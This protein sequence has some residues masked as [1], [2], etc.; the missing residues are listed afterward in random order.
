ML[1]TAATICSASGDP[2]YNTFD[3]AVHHYMGNCSYTLTKLCDVSSIEFPYFHVYTTNEHRGG[4]TKVSYIQ[5]VHV[6]V[7]NTNF[8]LLKNKKLNVD[9][10]R[11]NLPTALESRIRVHISGNY[12][13]LETNFGLQVR[14]DGNHYSDVSL[15]STFKGHVCGLCGNYNDNA[16]DDSLKPDGSIAS[17]SKE[18]GDSWLVDRDNKVCGSQDIENCDPNLEAEYSKDTVCGIITDTAGIFKDC[19]ALVNPDNFFENC[20]IDM[21][22]TGGDSNSLCYAVQAYAQQCS[23]AGICVEW[24]SDT[25]CP[26]SCP[27]RSYYKSC[28]TTCPA[29]CFNSPPVAPCKLESVEGCFCND[30]YVLSGDR[31]VNQTDC[32]CVDD[33]NNSY[34][35]G[36]SWFTYE[37]C[38]QRCSC[39]DNNSIVCENWQCGTLENCKRQDGVLGCHSSGITAC[40]VSGDPHFYTFDKVM[41]SFMGTCTYVLVD[42]CDKRS[43]IPFT[44]KGKTEDRG[45]RTATYLKEVYIDVYDFRIT[46][47]KD[48]KTLVDNTR[49]QTPWS[50]NVKGISIG[51]VGL[52]TVVTTDFG[53]IVKFDGNHHL[54]IVLPDAYFGKVCG[55]CGNFNTQTNDELLMSNG[56]LAANVTQFGNSWK[57]EEDSDKNCMDD[58]RVDLVPP[59]T[60]ATRPNIQNQC[61]VLLTDTFK[62]C[63]NLVSAD[64]FIESC[65]YDMCRYNGMVSTLCAIVQAY[66]DACRTQG[67]NIKWRSPSLCP[68]ACPKNSHYT[69]CASL[70]PSTCTNIYAP[71]VCDKPTTCMEGC[72]CDNGYALSGDQCVPLKSCGCRDSND[73]YYNID[74]SWITPHCTQ[75]C[76]CKKGNEIKCK[77]FSCPHGV[78]SVN[79]NGHYNCKPTG[80]SKCNIAGDPHYHTFDGLSHH[81]QGK[82]TYILARTSPDLPDYMEPFKIEGKNEAMFPFSRFS[83]LRELRIEVYNHVILFKQN[84]ILVL[85]SVR[86]VPPARPH[87]GIHI[88]QRPTRIYLETDFGLSISFDGKENAEIVVPNTYQEML[89]G[90]CGN[91]DGRRNND[92]TTPEGRLLGDVESFGESWNLK[93]LTPASRFRR[94]TLVALQEEDIIL[95]T[96]D[97]FACSA[98][99]LAFM[100]SSS[101]CGVMRDINGPF[102]NCIPYV[103]PE[104]FI[105]DCIFDT[106]AEFQSRELLCIN[107]EQYSI[108]CQQNET[109]VDDWRQLTGCAITCGSNSLYANRM[110]AC[111]ASCSNMASESEC[112]VPSCEGCQCKQGYVLSGFDCVPYIDCGCTFED[113]YYKKRESF[114]TND[115]SKNCTCLDTSSV[116]CDSME[117]KPEEECTTANQILGC[118][119]PSPCLENPCQNGGTCMETPGVGNATSISSCLC[120][121]THTGLYC[122]DEKE[123]NT[124]VIYIVIGVVVGVFVISLVFMV[125]AYF[126]LKSRKRK[127]KFLESPETS[128]HERDSVSVRSINMAY[129]EPQI[130]L[131]YA[132]NFREDEV[133][134]MHGNDNVNLYLE[135]EECG[136]QV[137][138]GYEDDDA[139]NGHVNETDKVT[140]F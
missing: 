22:L 105:V 100:N 19:H 38:T 85:D 23:D 113:K 107:L 58:T 25:F 36:E 49:I 47:Q 4:N 109:I 35:L 97:N 37:N 95:N 20:V 16:R 32:G 40:H 10:K 115:C 39:N 108:A 139:I 137:N 119:I 98:S 72:V 104:D 117:C 124:V 130:Q 78:C 3:G 80:F 120:P 43:V 140:I 59:C 46:L 90:L 118:Y 125:A 11:T 77:S 82:Q 60:T 21:C 91:F 33:N 15:L 99:G 131:N 86:T 127:S 93:S 76:Q 110:N 129:N 101:F 81:F 74:E 28:G 64:L 87:E 51:N 75:K 133:Q 8:T 123:A 2:H 116:I 112:E 29:T 121:S 62:A 24:R 61:N 89:Q 63:H 69:D 27:A 114:I 134:E 92:F 71:D 54:E 111:P 26:I 30:S 128:Q 56:L 50:G 65:V 12:L 52:Y 9:G 48:R 126:Y 5:S 136:A 73:N 122:E 31:C 67:V 53:M 103:S 18:L 66:V 17:D 84:K 55:M 79:K 44:I 6:E 94:D 83:L 102:K 88:Y 70:C 7:Y 138:L 42:I 14:F 1:N 135:N 57:S 68:L 132:E 45:Q 13:I 41:H 96:G 34:Q 106:C